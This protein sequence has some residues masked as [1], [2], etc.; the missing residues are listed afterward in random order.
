MLAPALDRLARQG[1][2]KSAHENATLLHSEQVEFDFLT[3][4]LQQQA[5][6][7]GLPPSAAAAFA[8]PAAA[9][10]EELLGSLFGF[11][12][13]ILLGQGRQAEALL[14]R[15][16]ARP[17]SLVPT[18]LAFPT[19]RLHQELQGARSVEA[20][21]P[22]AYA[23]GQPF[24]FKG[25]LD[26]ELVEALIQRHSPK[27]ISYVCVELCANGL[28]GQPVSLA[29]LRAVRLLTRRHGIPFF[30]DAT[31]ILEN[32]HQIRNLEPGCQAR[33]IWELVREICALA[34]GLTMSLTKD[35]ATPLGGLVACRD[36]GLYQGGLDVAM[37]MGDGLSVS[38]KR[39]IA[40]ALRLAQG[41]TSY[42]EQRMA[43]VGTL[44]SG[45]LA[46]SI[47]VLQPAGGHAVVVLLDGLL[48]HLSAGA[49]PAHALNRVWYEELG[50]RGAPHLGAGQANADAL[51]L[52]RLAIPIL[53]Y[54]EAHLDEVLRRLEAW[55]PTRRHTAGLRQ[56]YAPPVPGGAF[57][58][59]LA[60][61]HSGRP[62]EETGKIHA[63]A[64]APAAVLAD[65]GSAVQSA[66]S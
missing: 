9:D 47:P 30:L 40:T 37:A 36:E 8:R 62:G 6:D 44:H 35:F 53:K 27:Q 64:C 14:A 49:F 41:D 17:G 55:Y 39:S 2:L 25:N 19:T 7:W 57:R 20:L 10:V 56:V 22:E 61:V 21:T 38:A 4:S 3:D 29:N 46:R 33:P 26:L 66:N 45:L 63:A 42:I 32:A 48:D 65:A 60:P 51:G 28:G 31:R 1:F 5:G 58:A 23:P 13:H 34:D 50:I 43:L 52:F 18:N 59:W 15:L 11:P 16:C 24:P 12:Y 54:S